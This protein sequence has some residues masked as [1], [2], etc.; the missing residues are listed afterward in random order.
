M[1]F[2]PEF[3]GTVIITIATGLVG[4]TAWSFFE[5][6]AKNREKDAEFIRHDCRDRI[7]KLEQLLKD[8]AG[9]K[10]EMREL[11]LKL[12]AEVAELRVKVEW[13]TE[14]NHALI[15]KLEKESRKRKQLN[16]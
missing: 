13:L 4:T 5:R 10:D 16:D 3:W 6:R 11:I 9:E 8:S 7:S 1:N 2:S 12:T 15:T 14:E